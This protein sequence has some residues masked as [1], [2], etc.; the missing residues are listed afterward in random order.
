MLAREL[1]HVVLKHQLYL[2]NFTS[3]RLLAR[4]SAQDSIER[5][6]RGEITLN[7]GTEEEEE[8][9]E[10]DVEEGAKTRTRKVASSFPFIL[11]YLGW[12]LQQ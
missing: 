12:L 11:S 8:E 6:E 4:S 1:R 2:A 3:R 7:E 9:E 10:E 5:N